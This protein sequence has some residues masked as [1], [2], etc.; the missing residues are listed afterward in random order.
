MIPF[1]GETY[2]VCLD[3]FGCVGFMGRFVEEIST[4]SLFKDSEKT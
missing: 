4:S 3:P 1:R 2:L